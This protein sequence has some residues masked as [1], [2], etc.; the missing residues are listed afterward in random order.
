M[1]KIKQYFATWD[2]SRYLKLILGIIFGLAYAFDG[3]GFYMLLAVFFLV[4]AVMN[5]GC[6]CATGNCAT[7]IK[8]DKETSFQFEKLNTNKKDV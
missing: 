4:Q 2:S 1:R 6:G 5:I 8:K 3:Q 7:D